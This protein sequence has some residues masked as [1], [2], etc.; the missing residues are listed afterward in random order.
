[1]SRSPIFSAISRKKPGGPGLRTPSQNRDAFEEDPV[2]RLFEEASADQSGSLNGT[3]LYRLCLAL[4]KEFGN[5]DELPATYLR[6]LLGT[7]EGKK[8]VPIPLGLRTLGSIAFGYGVE[9]GYFENTAQ[10]RYGKDGVPLAREIGVSLSQLD[11]PRAWDL[12]RYGKEGELVHDITHLV[13]ECCET[14]L[15]IRAMQ[16]Y[17][18]TTNEKDAALLALLAEPMPLGSLA[19]CIAGDDGDGEERIE[20]ALQEWYKADLIT[21]DRDRIKAMYHRPVVE[22]TWSLTSEGR[23]RLAEI[24]AEKALV[25]QQSG[26][27]VSL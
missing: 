18:V 4:G 1:M 20:A 26:V 9:I 14:A 19:T 10:D 6:L 2:E 8:R 24:Y 22:G 15:V 16:I 12:L 25:A 17:R 5:F 23:E 21:K 7:F 11:I 27:D 3:P 13:T